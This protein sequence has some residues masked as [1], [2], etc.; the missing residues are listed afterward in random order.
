MKKLLTCT[1]ALI[2][3]LGTQTSFAG[4]NDHGNRGR[5]HSYDRHDRHDNGRNWGRDDRWDRRDR[6][7]VSVSLSFGNIWGGSSYN[8]WRYRDYRRATSG[9][10]IGYTTTW[11][12]PAWGYNNR[13]VI[14]HQNTYINEAPRT[15]VVTR[16]GRNSTSLFRDIDGNCFER[17]IDSRG[18]EIRTQLPSSECNF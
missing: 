14:V 18:D 13:P 15:R 16:P 9:I 12:A 3:L 1:A 11:G 8:D 2:L 7:N 6:D 5:G 17:V 10:G 4:H